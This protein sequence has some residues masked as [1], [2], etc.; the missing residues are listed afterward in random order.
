[1]YSSFEDIALMYA[2]I[3]CYIV[4]IIRL[5]V[6]HFPACGAGNQG[7]CFLT[8]AFECIISQPLLGWL[9]TGK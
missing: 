5:K 7:Y 8:V 4:K 2:I 6:V 9:H 3:P 1:M